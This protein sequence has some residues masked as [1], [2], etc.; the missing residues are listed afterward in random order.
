MKIRGIYLLLVMMVLLGGVSSC[1]RL[2]LSDADKHFARGEYYEAAEMYR[3][4]Y[5]KTSPKKRELRGEIAFKMGESYRLVNNPIRAN[6]AYA[7]AVRYKVGDSTLNLQYARTL[8]KE[9]KYKE[10]A[11]QY[12]EFLKNFPGNKFGLSGLEGTKLA[13]EWKSEPTPYKIKRMALFEAPKGGEFSPAFLPA[14]YNQVYFTAN[15]KDATGDTISDITGTKNNDIYMSRLDENGEW[16]KP[17]KLE[18]SINTMFDEGAVSFSKE[19]TTMYYTYSKQDTVNNT[20]PEIW[21][22]QRSGGA[23]G[24][25]SKLDIYRDTTRIYAHPSLTPSGR[26]LYFVSDMKGGYGGKD[27]WR[28]RM[29]GEVV[30]YVENL[31]PQ[32]NTAGDEM[33]PYARTDSVLYFSSDGHPGMGGLDIFKT[34]YDEKTKEW[35]IENM[36]PPVNSEGDDFGITFEGDKE[37]GFFSSNRGD[38]RGYDHIY[39]FEYPVFETKIEGYIVDTDDEFITLGATVRIVG[40]DGSI[41]KI[42]GKDDGTYSINAKGG[43][44]YV[45]LGSAPNHLNTKMMVKTIAQERDSTY[46]VDFILTPINKPVI[47]ENVFFDFDKY[48]LK[49]EAKEDLDGLITL[50]E[51]NPNVSIELSSHTDRKGEDEYN[52]RLSQ[53]RADAVVEYLISKGIVKDRLTSVGYGKR[54]PK[55]VTRS[56]V[57]KYDFLKEGDILDETFIGQLTPEQQEIADQINRRTE[58]KVLSITYNLE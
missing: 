17:E 38:A 39:W 1:K 54:Q 16:M 30:D 22:S 47:L 24:A 32:I 12:E 42:Q 55:T 49:A 51:L 25:G 6:A 58:F 4:I 15:H 50:L 13:T 46:L 34:V 20:F 10:A 28:A 37:K 40:N 53:R 41:N 11:L 56:I 26:Y 57:K 29:A 3:K 21:V 44:D 19:G 35:T 43:V 36:K 2:K 27:I 9:G 14:E 23:W 31:G 33:F 48:D 18:S 7:N 8:H 5:R 52:D 45:F